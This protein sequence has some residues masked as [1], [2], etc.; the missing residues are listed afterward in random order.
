VIEQFLCNFF[1]KKVVDFKNR[2]FIDF[3]ICIT[4]Q[5]ECY[6]VNCITPMKEISAKIRELYDALLVQK[7]IPEKSRFYYMK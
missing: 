2:L 5:I 1:N 6:R 4:P 3:S 7:K